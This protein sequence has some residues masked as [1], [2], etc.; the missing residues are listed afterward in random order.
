ME[1]LSILRKCINFARNAK[2]QAFVEGNNY[3]LRALYLLKL[4]KNQL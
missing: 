2:P 1:M 4:Q 3:D